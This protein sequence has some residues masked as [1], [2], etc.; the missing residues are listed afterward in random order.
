DLGKIKTIFWRNNIIGFAPALDVPVQLRAAQASSGGESGALQNVVL[1]GTWYRHDVAIPKGG[2]TFAT[3]VSVT[4]PWWHVDGRWFGDDAAECVVG[5]ALAHRLGIAMGQTLEVHTGDRT[6][7]MQVVGI[8]STG[9]QEDDAILAPLAVAQQLSNRPGE[10]RR[11][12]V[13][14][15]TKPE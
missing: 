1:I 11:L 9:G 6:T 14:A 3:G 8:V 12:M 10:Y 4:N 13:S 15:L 2:G 7:R 5:A